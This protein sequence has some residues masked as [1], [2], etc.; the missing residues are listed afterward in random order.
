MATKK[1][2]ARRPRDADAERKPLL[3]ALL[4]LAHE[5]VAEHVAQGLLSFGFDDLPPD[6]VTVVQPLWVEADGASISDLATHAGV[7]RASMVT[8]VDSLEAR[9]YVTVPRGRTGQVRLTERGR[10]L[11]ATI[12]AL[13]TAIENLWSE[14]FG[15]KRIEALRDTLT[16]LV[17][18]D[19]Q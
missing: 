4:R 16:A 19:W 7:T 10:T 9:G 1:K 5:S 6:Y 18:E 8:L 12:R 14:R 13:V 3:G 11:A 2:S 17:T 15:Q